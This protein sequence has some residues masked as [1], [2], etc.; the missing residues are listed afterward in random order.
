MLL[1]LKCSL[2]LPVRDHGSA[3]SVW[4]IGEPVHCGRV[5]GHVARSDQGADSGPLKEQR[6][7]TGT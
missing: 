5:R 7:G 6:A 1:G 2:Q 4:M 3:S